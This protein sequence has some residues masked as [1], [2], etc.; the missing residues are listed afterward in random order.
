MKY[1]SHSPEETKNIAATFGKTLQGGEFVAL[2]GEL[3]AGKTTFVQGL[4]RA[5]GVEEPVRSPTFTII[6]LYKSTHPTIK[7]IV[8][9]D[10]YRLHRGEAF[11][12]GLDEWLGRKDTIIIAEWPKDLEEL[13]ENIVKKHVEFDILS[14][15]DR[16]IIIDS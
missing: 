14:A 1:E 9:T 7:H 6:N 4:S 2:S 10:F 8:H 3:G 16:K 11:E 5:F 15:T 12:L 13:S